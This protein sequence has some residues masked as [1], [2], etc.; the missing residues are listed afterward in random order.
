MHTATA[1]FVM[2]AFIFTGKIAYK[3]YR[4]WKD[5]PT[6]EPPLNDEDCDD[7]RDVL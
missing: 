1:I 3:C 2:I 5:T 7:L 6:E 4:I